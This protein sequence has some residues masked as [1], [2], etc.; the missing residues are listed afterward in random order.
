MFRN[1][2]NVMYDK[3]FKVTILKD[4]I[5]IIN[6]QEVLIFEEETILIKTEERLVKIKGENLTIN[7]LYNKE[8]LIEGQIKTV[9]FG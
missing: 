9:E 8:L 2:T 5:D 7:R 3:A 4:K 6:Y 1:L